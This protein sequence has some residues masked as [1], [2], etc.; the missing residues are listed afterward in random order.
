MRA[1]RAIVQAEAVPV[2]RRL[3][4]ALVDDVD[5]DLRALRHPNRGAG[6]RAVV[7]QHSHR[8]IAD[9]LGH[10]RDLQVERGAV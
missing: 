9:A 1:V 8:R 5:L 3:K 4:I 7:G 2:H 6:D 10:R